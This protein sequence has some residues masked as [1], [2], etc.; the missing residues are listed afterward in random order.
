MEKPLFTHDCDSC[1]FLGTFE[2]H[3]LY[4]CSN[5]TQNTVIA[6]YGNDGCEYMSGMYFAEHGTNPYLVEAKRR[7]DE[8][9]L[10]TREWKI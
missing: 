8:L 3:D 5:D 1:R 9:G 7:A 4:Y 10:D 6:R 2:Q